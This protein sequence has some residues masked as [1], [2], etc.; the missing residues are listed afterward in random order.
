MSNSKALPLYTGGHSL[1]GLRQ[2]LV[3]TIGDVPNTPTAAKTFTRHT[4]T[5]SHRLADFLPAASSVSVPGPLTLGLKSQGEA[6]GRRSL[7]PEDM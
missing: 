4:H 2:V 6:A 3:L 1:K 5:H 7:S